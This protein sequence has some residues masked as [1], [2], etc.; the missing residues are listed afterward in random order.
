MSKVRS[1]GI[2][3]GYLEIVQQTNTLD[4]D[5]RQNLTKHP[6]V[7]VKAYSRIR[8]LSKQVQ[9][10]QV[11]AEGA[12]PQLA[13]MLE[14]TSRQL[15]TTLKEALENDLRKTLE[16]MKWP[17]KELNLLGD[18]PGNWDKQVR[19]LLELQDPDLIEVF[20]DVDIS[21]RSS[22]PDPVVLLPLE[23]MVQPLAVRFRYH[24]YGDKP[25]N[26]LDKPEYFLTHILD[27][28]ERHSGLMT[29]M[30]GPIL[31]ERAGNSES[32]ESI[33]TDAVSAFI[34]ALLPIVEAKCL[35]FLPQISQQPQLLS[36]FLHELM[37]FDGALRETWGFVPIPR[38]TADWQGLTGKM[39]DT[40]RYFENW[41]KVEKDFA[42]S[43]YRSIRDASDSNDIDFDAESGQTKPTK[44]SIRVNDLVETITDRYRGL[45]SFG[46]KMKFLLSIQLSIFDDYH[47]HLHGGLQ[48]FIL[49]SHT[50]GRLLQGQTDADAFSLKGL[51][52]LTK[53]FGSA[54][55]LERKMSDW[56]DDIFFIEL[57]DE[58]RY[59][60]KANTG[61]DAS[62]SPGLRVEDVAEKTSSSIKQGGGGAGG[63]EDIDIDGSGLFDQTATAFHRLREQSEEEMLR[64]F[65]INLKACLRPYARFSQRSS[66]A[67][68]P[69]TPS[70]STA[71]AP[72]PSLDSFFQT[73]ETLI[74]YLAR[75]IAPGALRRVVKHYCAA[76]Q[77]ELWDNVLLHHAFSASGAAQLARD[78]VEIKAT[79]EKHSR[80]RNAAGG[81]LRRLEEAIYLLSLD[82]SKASTARDDEDGDGDGWGFEDGEDMKPV[83]GDGDGDGEGELGLWEVERLIF[84]SNEAARSALKEMGLYHLSEGE[85]RNVL[86]RRVEL[87]GL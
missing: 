46:Q 60:A 49:S 13:Y 55:F 8:T 40:H 82:A 53:V 39:L 12:A 56:N 43:R 4:N 35:S 44:G 66:L 54:E 18:V 26:R 28:L 24:F 74:G 25:T 2:A 22:A 57:W 20:A 38:M 84:E 69:G 59:R 70:D 80:L 29:D 50:A 62:V 87:N 58:L 65:D 34:N 63:D 5:A 76:V 3:E 85:A 32:H 67:S 9:E 14:Q 52:S 6:A 71:M 17:G 11:A 36:H 64:F 86:K 1:L 31:D 78:V 7:S 30:L 16:Q 42:L 41:L 21:P 33:Y 15:F 72:S 61:A 37:A 77:R 73:T 23:V 68:T 45:S 75:A 10:A 51:E 27:L 83:A 48:A 79:V 47:N 81:G 19:L